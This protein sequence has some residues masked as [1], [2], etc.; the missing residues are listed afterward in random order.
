M[1][2]HFHQGA[3]L[4][5]IQRSGES[6][7]N[8]PFAKPYFS[9]GLPGFF[10]PLPHG[11]AN[12]PPFCYLYGEDNFVRRHNLKHRRIELKPL[13]EHPAVG[14]AFMKPSFC[15]PPSIYAPQE[16]KFAARACGKTGK[17]PN[18]IVTG[19][20]DLH[21]TRVRVLCE[22]NC[23]EIEQ[24][25]SCCVSRRLVCVHEGSHSRFGLRPD[26]PTIPQV[27][28]EVLVLQRLDPEAAF[29]NFV[30][31]NERLYIS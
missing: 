31:F 4:R 11:Q 5:V 9:A 13:A 15:A 18:R 21:R 29:G 7:K 27:T 1:S 17:P 10:K 23:F 24:A 12:I 30:R 20:A 3:R 19:V 2:S 25:R 14:K 26:A 22:I 8:L 28:N 16:R 6:Q